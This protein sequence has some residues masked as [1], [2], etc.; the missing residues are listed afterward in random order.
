LTP[1]VYVSL[2]PSPP[3]REV[4]RGAEIALEC[5]DVEVEAVRATDAARAADDPAAL[6]YDV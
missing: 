5:A 6:A 2:P 4:M 3:G 1:R